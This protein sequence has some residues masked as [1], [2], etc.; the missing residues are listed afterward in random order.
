[1]LIEL[2]Y[3]IK[4]LDWDRIVLVM[5]TS[6]GGPELLPFDLKTK[7][8]T[9]Y[10]AAQ[11]APERAPERKKPTTVFREALTT[12]LEHS[13]RQM[14]GVEI[15][16][17]SLADLACRAIEEGRPN[18]PALVRRF[19]ESLPGQLDPLFPKRTPGAQADDDL[20]AAIEETKPLVV[21]FSRVAEAIA[22]HGAQ[23]TART[24]FKGFE[25]I[26]A[27]YDVKPGFAGG[28]VTSSDFDLSKFVGHELMVT[29]VTLLLRDERWE[30]LSEVLGA[31]LIVHTVA[32]GRQLA[33]FDWLSQV[34]ELL[35]LR[36]SRVRP[37]RIS[38]HADLLKDRHTSDPLRVLTPWD[39]FAEAD[40]LL[41]L[42]GELE[43][44]G[45]VF[46]YEVP[47]HPW[48]A[49]LLGRAQPPKYLVEATSPKGA[50]TLAAVL[51]VA[52]VGSL[53]DRLTDLK[54]KQASTFQTWWWS[55]GGDGPLARFDPRTL[56]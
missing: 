11:E 18:A 24:L 4:Q 7:R 8:V 33:R 26:L 14:P 45:E 48:S 50:A 43:E 34:V 20:V 3:A 27:G 23:D 39:Q 54:S 21:D 10:E 36:N 56:G 44:R 30:I 29:L 38:T 13:Q 1:V 6:F 37:P 52:D 19:M 42:R 28:G 12:I 22:N 5:N 40:F 32:T 2:G 55:N 41:Y 47:W 17:A 46:W 25:N 51:G 15:N 49:A 35:S 53:R 16:P 9:T 31:S